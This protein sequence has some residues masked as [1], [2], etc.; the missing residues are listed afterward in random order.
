MHRIADEALEII[1]PSVP[2]FP[3]WE[4]YLEVVLTSNNYMSLLEGCLQAGPPPGASYLHPGMTVIG[5]HKEKTL[6][7]AM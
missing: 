1:R 3:L 7:A 6:T 5:T 4:T 2:F